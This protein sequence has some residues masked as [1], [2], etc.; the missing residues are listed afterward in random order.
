MHEAARRVKKKM[1][2]KRLAVAIVASHE[3]PRS[4]ETR[5]Q[6]R[7]S[8]E[9]AQDG[10]SAPQRR[11]APST[12]QPDA[13]TVLAQGEAQGGGG[14][15]EDMTIEV[16]VFPPRQAPMRTAIT[17]PREIISRVFSPLPR[18]REIPF[19]FESQR[20][21]SDQIRQRQELARI[22]SADLTE[23]LLKLIEKQDPQFGYSPEQWENIN[24]WTDAHS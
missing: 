2:A 3:R 23:A 17:I 24:A 6:R 15:N 12:R 7:Q 13:G 1:I 5:Q 22:I 14:V 9:P 8:Q 11:H 18:D 21:A 16:G 10:S 20:I 19:A 4:N